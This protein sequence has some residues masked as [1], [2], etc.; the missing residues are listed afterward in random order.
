MNRWQQMDRVDVQT[1]VSRRN[2]NSPRRGILYHFFLSFVCSFFFFPFLLDF[3]ERFVRHVCNMMMICKF[4]SIYFSTFFGRCWYGRLVDAQRS[5]SS[6]PSRLFARMVKKIRTVQILSFNTQLYACQ[7][8][9]PP[10]LHGHF[11]LFEGE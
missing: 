2:W 3:R 9:Y 6:L 7:M 1:K 8:L 11:L 10:K 5:S 4:G